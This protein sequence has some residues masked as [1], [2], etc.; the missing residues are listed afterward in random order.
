MASSDRLRKLKSIAST[1]AAVSVILSVST[2]KSYAD[3]KLAAGDVMELA[4]FGISDFQ[5][6]V[7]IDLDGNAFFPLIGE[8]HVEGRTIADVRRQVGSLMA[9]KDFRVFG[10]SGRELHTVVSPDE[11]IL[12]VA[13]YR[14][15]VVGGDV[16]TP[17]SQAFR[18]GL[19]VRDAVAVA[20][21]YD[22]LHVKLENPF[23]QAVQFK[24]ELEGLKIDLT[25]E[26]V[27]LAGLKAE[28][29]NTKEIAPDPVIAG[30]VADVIRGFELQRVSSRLTDADLQRKYLG[31]VITQ[32]QNRLSSLEDQEGKERDGAKLDEDESAKMNDLLQRG[33]VQSTRATDARRTSLLSSTRFLET[34]VEAEKTRKEGEDLKR[35]LT[36]F[37]TSRIID[38]FSAIQD[39]TAKVASLESQVQGAAQKYA[40]ITALKSQIGLGGLGTKE[41]T[42]YRKNGEKRDRIDGSEETELQPGD[43]IEIVL[44]INDLTGSSAAQ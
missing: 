4:A 19:S 26:K 5:S 44:R 33:L 38:L 8:L 2:V 18:P 28:L 32:T 39:S 42:I 36:A 24:T 7:S 9:S 23:V 3:Y 37:D 27:R 17:G 22:L 16:L 20:G 10:S 30:P 11:L 13:E 43:T 6:R 14:P 15:V 12:R 21:G 41:I 25:R 1:V 40:A 29:D 31:T 35:Q 34:G